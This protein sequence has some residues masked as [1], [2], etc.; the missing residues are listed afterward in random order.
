MEA[1]RRSEFRWVVTG[2]IVVVGVLVPQSTFGTILGLLILFGF[3]NAIYLFL[4]PRTRF[5]GGIFLIILSVFPLATT[6]DIEWV[7]VVGALLFAH[8]NWLAFTAAARLDE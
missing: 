7:G 1:L 5:G 6:L 4:V 2:A 3:W 8:G